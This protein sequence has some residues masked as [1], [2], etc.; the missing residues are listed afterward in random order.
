[1][2]KQYLYC[3]FF[4]LG[5]RRE[6]RVEKSVFSIGE[7]LRKKRKGNLRGGLKRKRMRDLNRTHQ[8]ERFCAGKEEEARGS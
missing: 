8:V 2:Y 5:K 6:K 4:F 7:S 3:F 1:M